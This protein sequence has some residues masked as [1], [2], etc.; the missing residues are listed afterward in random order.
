MS[1]NPSLETEKPP[2]SYRLEDVS[3]KVTLHPGR[4][5]FPARSVNLFGTGTGTLE[6]NGQKQTFQYA[7]KD[8]MALLSEFYKIRFFELPANYSVRHSVFLKDD[9][10]IGTTML[11]MLDESSTSVC[12]AIAAYEKCVRYSVQGPAELEHIV[13]RIFSEASKR[14]NVK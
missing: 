1:A 10:T 13:T 6:Q 3:V 8:M 12:I 9:G 14:V 7:T 4:G 11:R 2:Q 5:A